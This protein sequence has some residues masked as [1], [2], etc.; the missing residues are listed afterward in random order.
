MEQLGNAIGYVEKLAVCTD[1]CKGLAATVKQV[2][3]WVEHREC[4]KHLMDNM[5]KN[6]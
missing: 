1:A 2:F 3:P 4:F 5:K 6:Y